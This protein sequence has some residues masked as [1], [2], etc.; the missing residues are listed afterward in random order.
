LEEKLITVEEAMTL[1]MTEKEIQYIPT[2][3]Q[4]PCP[5]YPTY[6]NPFGPFYYSTTSDSRTQK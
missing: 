1:M 5:N 3:P 6:P 4:T 2:I